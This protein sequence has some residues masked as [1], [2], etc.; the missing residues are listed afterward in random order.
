M[1]YTKRRNNIG[2]GKSKRGKSKG[3]KSKSR[4]FVSK[5]R[6]RSLKG[7]AYDTISFITAFYENTV[8][9]ITINSHL[10]PK[11]ANIPQKYL[12]SL[13][14][15]GISL[16]SPKAEALRVVKRC[17][18]IF[19][20]AYS[21]YMHC[22]FEDNSG[23]DY[24]TR[25]D[26]NGR[27]EKVDEL[28][29]QLFEMVKSNWE[30]IYEEYTSNS[31]TTLV[32]I[33]YRFTEAAKANR[34]ITTDAQK[35]EAGEAAAQKKAAA[36]ADRLAMEQATNAIEQAKYNKLPRG[37]IE[38]VKSII[39]RIKDGD[40]LSNCSITRDQAEL[41]FKMFGEG[42]T[43]D[44]TLDAFVKEAFKRAFEVAE[45]KLGDAL[46][47]ARDTHQG[48]PDYETKRKNALTTY[49]QRI[50][51]I[52]RIK[53]DKTTETI[54]SMA[55]SIVTTHMIY[56]EDFIRL[57]CEYTKAINGISSDFSSDYSYVIRR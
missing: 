31:M 14:T 37:F 26:P 52:Q 6:G 9:F 17:V 1:T 11:C 30:T 42:Y 46:N 44:D 57:L 48:V 24:I 4:S 43:I 35:K 28:I 12:E 20:L 19:A 8:G 53:Y 45:K 49:K 22:V 39:I 38:G 16:V 34:G 56:P 21:I 50:A 13:N 27:S 36:E 5:R 23:Y 29:P 15:F 32:D 18:D 33:L 40:L 2:R 7:G 51:E 55:S 41:I 25:F 54:E 47:F 3:G 10:K